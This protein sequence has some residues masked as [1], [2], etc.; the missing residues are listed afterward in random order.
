MAICE[1]CGDAIR[2]EKTVGADALFR[3]M[4]TEV[5]YPLGELKHRRRPYVWMLQ[6]IMYSMRMRGCK[7]TAIADAIGRD[8]SDVIYGV[9]QV[10]KRLALNDAPTAE[11]LQRLSAVQ[12]DV[13][14]I[15][16]PA[17]SLAEQSSPASGQYAI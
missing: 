2:R 10:T 17:T 12:C 15:T 4:A 7:F 1:R 6:N 11:Q 16:Q 14:A 5:N 8:H 9:K 3:A 13:E